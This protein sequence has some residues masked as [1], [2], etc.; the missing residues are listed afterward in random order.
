MTLK[1]LKIELK[2][3]I[4]END[5]GSVIEKLFGLI[6]RQSIRF[7]ELISLKGQLHELRQKESRGVISN[8]NLILEANKIR[9]RLLYFVDSIKIDD[10]QN[11]DVINRNAIEN[12]EMPQEIETDYAL[13][14]NSPI[15]ENLSKDIER[16]R[17]SLINESVLRY[18]FNK[19]FVIGI[20]PKSA[21]IF[22]NREAELN[23]LTE[24]IEA[25][26]K[27]VIVIFGRAGMGK[28][29]IASKVLDE[30]ESSKSSNQD[31]IFEGIICFNAQGGSL[32]LDRVYS[33][34][35]QFLEEKAHNDLLTLWQARDVSVEYKARYLIS[36]LG[37]RKFLILIDNFEDLLDNHGDLT[38]PGID[39]FMKAILG[40]THR[41]VILITS[42]QIPNIYQ[43]IV[44]AKFIR[45]NRGLDIEEAILFLKKLDI[46]GDA[47][48][49]QKDEKVL[50]ELSIR[51]NGIP[52]A[53]EYIY[54]VLVTDQLTTPEDL[55]ESASLW[56][57]EILDRLQNESFRRL[58]NQEARSI[59]HALAIFGL[60]VP[61]E[62]LKKILGDSSIEIEKILR[63][64]L[65]RAHI[66]YESKSKTYTLH[67]L[68]SEYFNRL[69]SRDKKEE[70]HAKAA[71]YFIRLRFPKKLWRTLSDLQPH[72]DEFKHRVLANQFDFAAQI[73][74]EIEQHL[75]LWGQIS[76]W[77]EMSNE[78]ENVQ[79]NPIISIEN[80]MR[81]GKIYDILGEYNKSLG[82][83]L[84]ALELSNGV[85]HH[86]LKAQLY[87]EVG[88]AYDSNG[89]AQ[90][91]IEKL[92]E[93]ISIAEQHNDEKQMSVCYRI[94]ANIYTRLGVYEPAIEFFE[95]GIKLC[96]KINYNEGLAN[97]FFDMY[98]LY[99][100]NGDTDEALAV[101]EQALSLSRITGDRLQEVEILR[102]LGYLYISKLGNRKNEE[103][104]LAYFDQANEITDK[105][106]NKRLEVSNTWY[107]CL[108]LRDAGQQDK[109]LDLLKKALSISKSLMD[110]ELITR[111]LGFFG[112][113]YVWTGRFDEA[114]LYYEE[115]L[116]IQLKTGDKIGEANTR[117][118]IADIHHMTG[119][120][121][122]AVSLCEKGLAISQEVSFW[123]LE[124]IFL[125]NL[126]RIHCDLEDY[127]K[128]LEYHNEAIK[129]CKTERYRLFAYNYIGD[130]FVMLDKENAINY[131]QKA[132][133]V[134][135]RGNYQHLQSAAEGR[136]AKVFHKQSND[137]KMG[138]KHYTNA[139]DLASEGGI[140]DLRRKASYLS[141]IAICYLDLND[142]VAASK[143]L[144][145]ALNL[146][147]RI[148]SIHAFADTYYSYSIFYLHQNE[149]EQVLINLRKTLQTR[150]CK[151]SKLI[152]GEAIF[153]PIRN[154]SKFQQL[155]ADFLIN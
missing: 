128:S 61:I 67:P 80:K 19:A 25:N 79:L 69:L 34:V 2:F 111:C 58:T 6:S 54:A 149:L 57:E 65:K 9:E 124:C 66:S 14:T 141:S 28:T 5:T 140:Y 91:A 107:Q 146:S 45:I 94:L 23:E 85:E 108:I 33:Q 100:Q 32:S 63:N 47:G 103:K 92:N 118:G 87:C 101:T 53:L 148:N 38:A 131:Y 104:A 153:D 26:D 70:L 145:K 71:D 115:E 72:L 40:L 27:R 86:I 122:L 84:A 136:L 8:T 30:L 13:K 152:R 151:Y 29:A 21:P 50:R 106:G 89:K 113:I 142:L 99:I 42:R 110:S 150:I 133:K 88:K 137:P 155:L 24:A 77:E 36:Q 139:I 1:E 41:I 147:K 3:Q 55:L 109:A 73:V 114:L 90:L 119:N 127:E 82:A 83:F 102:R 95:K 143:Y 62:A 138:I 17:H 68:D 37:D 43:G 7:N 15:A 49:L 96:K 59:M 76:Q 60:P 154:E 144:G 105:L 46:T 93:S 129:K 123:Q 20:R 31:S 39:A 12:L 22:I 4:A 44:R 112:E 116:A 98:Y 18:H 74:T 125:W 135:K 35:K 78:L 75:E 121:E 120:L 48:L 130:T 51:A 52:R 81:L 117:A 16:I 56:Q 11:P 97:T 134:A 126:G 132:I 10:L 64:L